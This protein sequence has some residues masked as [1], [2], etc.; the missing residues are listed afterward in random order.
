MRKMIAITICLAS[1]ATVFA[2]EETGVVVNGV[3]WATCNVGASTPEGYGNYYNFD[4]A[5]RACPTGWRTPT[6]EEFYKLEDAASVWTMQNGVNGRRFGSGENTIFLPAAGFRF[7]SKSKF[8]GRDAGGNYWANTVT[9]KNGYHLAFN[10]AAGV[11][12][13]NYHKT[14]VMSVRCVKE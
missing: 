3:T 1:S 5:Q 13:F 10:D 12:I 11:Y 2:Q 8:H 14:V 4:E 7:H 6:R 9:G